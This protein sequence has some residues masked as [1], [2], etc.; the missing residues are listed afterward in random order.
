MIKASLI[1]RTK[2]AKALLEHNI[3]TVRLEE[4]GYHHDFTWHLAAPRDGLRKS[5][6]LWILCLR[7]KR[8]KFTKYSRER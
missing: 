5:V 8:D 1:T 6:Q 7:T 2:D 3:M 4:N